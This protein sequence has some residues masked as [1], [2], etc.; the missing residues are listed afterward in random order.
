[1]YCFSLS[2]HIN[3]DGHLTWFYKSAISVNGIK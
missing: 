1:L 3:N 2:V